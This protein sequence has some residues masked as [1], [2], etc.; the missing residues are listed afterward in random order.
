MV[1]DSLISKEARLLK[2]A[3]KLYKR[4]ERLFGSDNTEA[5]ELLHEALDEI[6]RKKSVIKERKGDFSLLFANIGNLLS[7]L[8][9]FKRGEEAFKSAM[10]YDS[11]N[12]WAYIYYARA[13]SKRRQF[14]LAL[15]MVDKAITINRKSR[16]AWEVKAEIYE[17]M[18]DVDEAL[19]IYLNLISMFPEEM[20]YYDAYLKYKPNDVDILLKK[21]ILLYNRGDYHN[22]AKVLENV[23]EISPG[24]EEA[25]IYLGASYDKM[26]RYED[27]IDAFRK[28]IEINPENKH[29]WMNL[30]VIYKKRGEYEDALNAVREAIKIDPND[31]KCWKLKSEIE[32]DMEDYGNALESINQALGMEMEGN[33]LIDALLHKR[34]ILK[35]NYVA[36]QMKN[37]CYQLIS[38]GKRDLDIYY[39]LAE[40]YYKLGEYENALEVI[41]SI[42]STSPHH[43]PTLVLQKNTYMK[44][45][46]WEKAINSGEKILEIDPKNVE[47]MVDITRAYMELKKYESALY[48]I[49]R[50][51]EIAPKNVELWKLQRDI[52]KELNKPS[53]V[54]NA[55]L[56]ITSI[57]EDFESLMDLARAYYSLQRFGEAK[58]VMDRAL[59]IREDHADAWNLYGMINYKLKD[60]EEAKKAFEKAT[61]LEP[62]VKKYWSNLGWILEKLEKYREAV[63]AFNRAVELDSGDMRIWY[64][65]GLCLE[66]LGE[67]EEALNSF[68]KAL[69][70][71]PKFIKA[72]MAR[73]NVHLKMEHLDDAL[74]E[75][76]RV[77]KLEPNNHEALYKKAL[78]EFKRGNYEACRRDVDEALKYRKEEDYLVL[79][80]DC[81]RAVKDW[82]CVISVAEDV[83]EMN[84]RNADAFRDLAHAY[85]KVGKIDSAIA[86]YRRALEIFPEDE[87]FLYEL[88][89]LLLQEAERG[90]VGRYAEVVE[91]SKRIL[92][93]NP[94]DFHALMDI[95]R[96]YVAMEKYDEAEDYLLRALGVKRTKEVYDALGNLYLKRKDY[97]GALK[98]FAESLKIENDPEVHYLMAYCHFKM[99]ELEF[100]TTSIRKAMRKGKKAKYYLLGAKISLER[101][102]RSNAIKYGKKALS[103]ED[104][105]E[106][107]LLLGRILIESGENME[108]IG[109][110]KPLR[111]AEDPLTRMKALELLAMASEREGRYDEALELY[112]EMLKLDSKS[113]SAYMGLGRVNTA[114]GKHEEAKE[115]FEKAYRLN[116]RN[117]EVCESLAFTYE[118]MG[119]LNNA[120]R[121]IDAAIEIEPENK[122]LWN[123]KGRIL[124]EMK[125]YREAK[126]AYEK[127][128]SIDSEFKP[129]LEGLRDVERKIEEMEIE[130][131]ARKVLELEYRTGK[132]VTKKVAFKKLDIPLAIIPK[133]FDYIRRE[134]PLSVEEMS[135]E[136]RKKYERA[137]LVIAKKLGKIEGIGLSEIIGNTSMSVASAKRLLKYIEYC[138]QSEPSEDVSPEDERM[139]KKALDLDLKNISPLNLMMNLDIGIC[140]AMKIQRILRDILEDEEMEEEYGEEESEHERTGDE[141]NEV[142]PAGEH[143]EEEE[144]VAES[145]EEEELRL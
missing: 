80:K 107:R 105:P 47:A 56:G 104:S 90:D 100:A 7:E 61:Q 93:I 115:A 106:I 65:R 11:R 51:T 82:N 53:E 23:I 9:D 135:E 97:K 126:R 128:L 136:D 99:G 19:K 84:A 36:D 67:D 101:G 112:R 43:L 110:L 92:A 113:A 122:Y 58:K 14:D 54:V 75:F 140:Q 76:E 27:S 13:L 85:V 44:L 33:E 127:A 60:F 49:K 29:A 48:F 24:N 25:Y 108:A 94:E 118:K 86:T 74:K 145:E 138:L 16:E 124:A 5:M 133:V 103:I 10:L 57:V 137:S 87:T 39:D 71:N 144:P 91:V 28:A 2:K 46:R 20:K 89:D 120:L 34:K 130:E 132:K 21:G 70:I 123:S 102:D 45:G 142:T 15:R 64:E 83:L 52:A 131:Y 139:V 12:I 111:K 117:R 79:K 37:A 55:C 6:E 69:E 26:E 73:G 32:Y 114:L 143:E 62:E 41:E 35:R 98:Y 18:H 50:A 66:K 40:A 129:A 8:G 68:S 22:A 96:A 1:L 17:G 134:E 38:R 31:P 4:G 121:Y 42:L 109:I 88:K 141:D 59:R 78:I 81:C 77:L 125:K 63:D 30:A 119:D 116:P 72:I 95:A 3:E